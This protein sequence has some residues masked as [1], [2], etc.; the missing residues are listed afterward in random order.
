MSNI[1]EALGPFTFKNVT[2]D[3]AV[4]NKPGYLKRVTINAVTT[5][6]VLTLYN[7]TSEAAPAIAAIN[8]ATRAAGANVPTYIDF[9][10]EFGTG[11]YAGF[12][13]TLVCDLTFV[14]R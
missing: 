4:K 6:G 14:Y 5:G 10:I 7:N 11:L 2:A 9:D 3:T 13:A 8:I 1:N 12:D